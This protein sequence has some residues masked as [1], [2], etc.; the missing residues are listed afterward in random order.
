MA[1]VVSGDMKCRAT[2]FSVPTRPSAPKKLQHHLPTLEVSD[3]A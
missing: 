3:A 1:A 2:D